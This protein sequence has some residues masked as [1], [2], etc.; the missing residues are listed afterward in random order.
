MIVRSPFAVV[1]LHAEVL[2]FA[3]LPFLEL[4]TP[5]MSPSLGA[6]TSSG[7]SQTSAY[8]QRPEFCKQKLEFVFRYYL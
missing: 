2:R 1:L 4:P 5:F 7:K 8:F 3:V 6:L